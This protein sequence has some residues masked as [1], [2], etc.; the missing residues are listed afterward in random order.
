VSASFAERRS[1]EWRIPG[2]PRSD[3]IGGEILPGF[4]FFIDQYRRLG[5]NTEQ[6]YLLWRDE[7]R[8]RREAKKTG[9]GGLVGTIG[10]LL[11][12]AT[13]VYPFVRIAYAWSSIALTVASVEAATRVTLQF[14]LAWYAGHVGREIEDELGLDSHWLSAAFAIGAWWVAG[15]L[16][17]YTAPA[18]QTGARVIDRNLQDLRDVLRQGGKMTI[19]GVQRTG[20]WFHQNILPFTPFP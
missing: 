19:G 2:P 15:R 17:N 16:L 8:Q 9:L 12:I 4:E 5:F 20:A 14:G 11:H 18:T 10:T 6:A 3:W 13:L 1:L 7:Q